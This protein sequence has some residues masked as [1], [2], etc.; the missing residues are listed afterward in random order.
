M[1][2]FN[3]VQVRLQ[4]SCITFTE[5]HNELT[6]LQLWIEENRADIPVDA[7][8]SSRELCDLWVI[9]IIENRVGRMKRMTSVSK[10]W[11]RLGL[12]SLNKLYQFTNILLYS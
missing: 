6:N 3:V 2:T 7:I 8:N 5:A 1:S 12:H 10:P 9:E 4:S 11:M